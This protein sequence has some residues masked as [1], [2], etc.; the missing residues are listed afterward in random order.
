[1]AQDTE[2]REVA[3]TMTDEEEAERTESTLA[4]LVPHYT[5]YE[6]RENGVDIRFEGA[7]EALQNVAEFISNEKECC[8]F[9]DYEITVGPPYDETVLTITG[10]DGTR[11]MFR[12]AFAERLEAEAA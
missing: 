6:E 9:A 7:S 3:C 1:M 11:P 4:L 12:D 10:P 8:S 5:G 2:N